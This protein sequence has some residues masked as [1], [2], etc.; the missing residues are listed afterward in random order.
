MAKRGMDLVLF[1]A[2][3]QHVSQ[4]AWKPSVKRSCE[5]KGQRT[6]KRLIRSAGVESNDTQTIHMIYHDIS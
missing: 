6:A 1:M 2:A 4:V 3:A 5:I